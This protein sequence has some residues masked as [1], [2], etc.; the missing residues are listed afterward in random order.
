MTP[1]HISTAPNYGAENTKD[2]DTRSPGVQV[3]SP[4]LCRRFIFKISYHSVTHQPILSVQGCNIYHLPHPETMMFC[5]PNRMLPMAELRSLLG[6]VVDILLRL[7]N[8]PLNSN[9]RDSKTGVCR[10]HFCFS[11]VYYLSIFVQKTLTQRGK[12]C[13]CIVPINIL[14]IHDRASF[15]LFH[16][17][18]YKHTIFE[19][20]D[21]KTPFTKVCYLKECTPAER[22]LKLFISMRFFYQF[23]QW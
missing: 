2:V 5:S 3:F 20:I 1:F 4:R 19:N 18:C 7:E 15:S 16:I 14:P 21:C 13:K 22:I 6:G 9:L 8:R 17:L 12:C 10:A 11:M 23:T